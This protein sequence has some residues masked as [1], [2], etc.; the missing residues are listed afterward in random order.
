MSRSRINGRGGGNISQRE[1][2]CSMAEGIG[3][4]EFAVFIVSYL[5]LAFGGLLL[6]HHCEKRWWL[7]GMGARDDLSSRMA[8][9]TLAFVVGGFFFHP[10]LYVIFHGDKAPL[11]SCIWWALVLPGLWHGSVFLVASCEY[12]GYMR[13]RSAKLSGWRDHIPPQSK[14]ELSEYIKLTLD[15]PEFAVEENRWR[16]GDAEWSRSRYYS[17]AGFTVQDEQVIIHLVFMGCE[18][19]VDVVLRVSEWRQFQERILAA[20]HEEWPR[21]QERTREEILHR[22]REAESEAI[23]AEQARR[24]AE[25]RERE[26]FAAMLEGRSRSVAV[27]EEHHAQPEPP[28]SPRVVSASAPESAGGVSRIHT[29]TPVGERPRVI[30]LE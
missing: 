4:A 30:E 10:I 17:G 22:R 26:A 12:R 23:R 2:G 9:T 6:R 21:A 28:T 5:A 27:V 11:D 29:F 7:C 1:R 16:D 3:L 15:F 25:Q 18:R 24:E 13:N 20:I 14:D 8:G 19:R